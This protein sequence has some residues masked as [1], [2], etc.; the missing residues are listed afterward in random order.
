MGENEE[1]WIRTKKSISQELAHQA[2]EKETK[3]KTVLPDFYKDYAS[4]FDKHTLE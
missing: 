2:E 4:V 1:V 3:P